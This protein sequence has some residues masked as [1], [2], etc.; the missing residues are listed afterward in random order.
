MKG[1]RRIISNPPG[2]KDFWSTIPVENAIAFAGV[3]TGKS[4]AQEQLNATIRGTTIPQ[5]PGSESDSGTKMEAAAVL[6]MTLE[7]KTA[8]SEKTK[9]T[10]KTGIGRASILAIMM[11]V[12]PT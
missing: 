4:R 10:P 2:L 7:I 11:S 6:L 12:K 8:I 5:I 9:A 1:P 3:E